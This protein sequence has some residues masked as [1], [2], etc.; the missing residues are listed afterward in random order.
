[1]SET[2]NSEQR[3]SGLSIPVPWSKEP[4]KVL[5]LGT[6]M[7]LMLVAVS[8][9]AYVLWEHKGEAKAA[10]DTF[11]SAVREMTAAQKDSTKQQRLMNCIISQPQEKREAEFSASNSFCQRMSSP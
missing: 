1:M 2:P 11:V 4:I 6:V 8:L 9:M 7:T 10:T 5:G 3:T